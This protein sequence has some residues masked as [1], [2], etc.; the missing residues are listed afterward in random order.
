ML[1][2]QLGWGYETISAMHPV[3]AFRFATR[4][5][6]AAADQL[7][8]DIAL[9][10]LP[11][12]LFGSKQHSIHDSLVDQVRLWKGLGERPK[13]LQS[14]FDEEEW[15]AIQEIEAE[16]AEQSPWYADKERLDK[17]HSEF[18]RMPIG[19]RSAKGGALTELRRMGLPV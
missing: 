9:F 11:V 5:M 2:D 13:D 15:A 18:G 3:R 1:S 8:D 14:M 7:Q 10:S 19:S 4:G 16:M 6:E 12:E 17:V